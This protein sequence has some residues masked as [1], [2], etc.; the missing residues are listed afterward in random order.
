[1]SRKA[2]ADAIS[3]MYAE[4][5]KRLR[6]CLRGI[7]TICSTA[8]CWTSLRRHVILSTPTLFA[9]L[10]SLTYFL[11]LLHFYFR[12]Y[13][14]VAA[15]WLD[16]DC[17]RMSGVLSCQRLTGHHTQELLAVPSLN[18]LTQ[19]FG[20]GSSAL[21]VYFTVPETVDHFLLNCKRFTDPSRF[22]VWE[23]TI[24]SLNILS[25]EVSTKGFSLPVV[26]DALYSFVRVSKRLVCWKLVQ[27]IQITA[28]Q[29][30]SLFHSF[31]NF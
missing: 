11:K 17:R 31:L 1:M 26:Q 6:T 20:F 8:D 15:H 30:F 24:A 4:M 13:L 2:I 23:I 16:E 9:T 10:L 28:I 5:K 18:V 19:K 14:G 22:T 12:S 29:L 25:F 3:G 27:I 21:C 7:K